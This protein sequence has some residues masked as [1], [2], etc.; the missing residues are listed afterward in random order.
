MRAQ[1]GRAR[2][3]GGDGVARAE[4]T[5]VGG[6]VGALCLLRPWHARKREGRQGGL[7]A[8]GRWG[9]SPPPEKRGRCTVHPAPPA[10]AQR[11]GGC[12]GEAGRVNWGWGVE[13][14][15]RR[16]LSANGNEGGGALSVLRPHR[17]RKG[18]EG[19][20]GRSGA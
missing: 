18:V 14:P 5:A 16:G 17:P 13:Q 11:R 15:R 8:N 7:P 19:V 12:A 6:K 4:G 2:R 10:C 1:R 3:P 20:W 9:Q